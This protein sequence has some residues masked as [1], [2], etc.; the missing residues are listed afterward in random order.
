MKT[1]EQIKKRI[2]ELEEK[3]YAYELNGGGW[4]EHAYPYD[5]L[6]KLLQWALTNEI[7]T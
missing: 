2:K 5:D 7:H 1:E 4:L 3:K 6:I